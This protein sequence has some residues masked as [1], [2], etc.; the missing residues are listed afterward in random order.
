MAPLLPPACD[1]ELAANRESTG[2]PG[3]RTAAQHPGVAHVQKETAVRV[4]EPGRRPSRRRLLERP[5]GAANTPPGIRGQR[6]GSA[7]A[8]RGGVV[9]VECILSRQ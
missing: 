2:T 3:R 4:L 7:R 6:S 1:F 8:A 9:V 5:Q